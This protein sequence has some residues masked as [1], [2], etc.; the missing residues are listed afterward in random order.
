MERRSLVS[1]AVTMSV[2]GGDVDFFSRE[3]RQILLEEAL[4]APSTAAAL[5][6]TTELVAD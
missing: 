5:R 4:L 3:D 6:T 2:I 1:I